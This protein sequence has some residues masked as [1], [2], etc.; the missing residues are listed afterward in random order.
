MKLLITSLMGCIA[1]GVVRTHSEE[2]YWTGWK[3]FL[4]M[5]SAKERHNM[6]ATKAEHDLRFEIFKDNMEKIKEHKKGGH[7]WRMGITQFSDMTTKEFKEYISCGSLKH[8]PAN[9]T[10]DAPKSWNKTAKTSVD[11]VA[12]GA[13]T[14]V[15]NQGSCGSCWAFSTTGAIEGRYF[16]AKGKLN[17]LS[18]QDLVDC[19]KEN[20]G[21]NGGL[22][23]YGFDFVETNN[24]LCNEDEYAYTGT[25]HWRCKENGCTKYDVISTYQD[26]TSSTSALES[27]CSDGP[28]SIAIEADQDS[29]QQYTGGVLTAECGT[30]LDHGVLLV[31]YGTEG[32]N[33]YWNV[34][35]SWGEDWGESGYIKLCRNC[36]A[37][38]G[39]GQC[40]ILSTAS[41]PI[42]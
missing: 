35:N 22:M 39:K 4:S 38:R 14:P 1:L 23:D 24:G 3:Q 34:K 36:H 15:K 19:S 40:G 29:F 25:H 21:C 9:S 5:E 42:V 31:G 10:H 26:V 32:S 27:A 33:D 16:I 28:V 41:Y 2:E 12:K 6:Y 17:S 30:G 37:N 7:S 20:N 8:K 18:E 11:W 13:V